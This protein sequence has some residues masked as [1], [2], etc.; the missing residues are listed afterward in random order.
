MIRPIKFRAWNKLNEKML[1]KIKVMHFDI[2]EDGIEQVYGYN[3]SKEPLSDADWAAM[4]NLVVMQFTG[5]KD[6]NGKEIYE[7]DILKIIGDV[8]IY[9]AI[10]TWSEDGAFF[11]GD[12]K[13]GRWHPHRFNQ[14]EVI[15]NI[16]ENPE[17]IS[18]KK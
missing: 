15:G 6:K 2:S 13:G 11:Y 17:L 1:T 9:T 7:G 18:D 10:V 16:Y 4:D 5:L 14:D 8:G 3:P 12:D